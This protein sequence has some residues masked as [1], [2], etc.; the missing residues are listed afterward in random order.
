MRHSSALRRPRFRLSRLAVPVALVLLATAAWGVDTAAGGDVARNVE[1]AG[2]DLGGKERVELRAAVDDY[3]TSVRDRPVRLVTPTGELATTAGEL[4]LDVD[5]DGTVERVLDAGR[6]SALLRPLRWVTSFVSPHDVEPVFTSDVDA[7]Y[8]TIIGLEGTERVPPVEPSMAV[9]DG[10][11]VLVPSAPGSGIDTDDVSARLPAA[12]LDGADPIVLRVDPIPL[13]PALDDDAV[14]SVVEEANAVTDVPLV[15]RVADATVDVEPAEQRAWLRLA[16]GPALALDEDVAIETLAEE[17]PDLGSPP[18]DATVTLGDGG[19]PV[20]VPGQE[21]TGC[22]EPGSG[23]LLLEAMRDGD[24]R[25]TLEATIRPPDVTTD[26]VESWAIREPVGGARAWP[27]S[28]SGEVG[29]GF[30]TFHAAGEARV[31]NIQRIADLVRGAVIPPGGQFSVN[32][33]VGRRTPEKG[34]VA[35]GA[36][37]NGMHV[38][39]VGGGVSQFATTLFNAAY[40]AGLDIVEYQAHSEYFSRYPRG[41]EATMGYPAPDLRIENTTPFGVLIWTSY[42]GSSLTVTMYS[43]PFV[44][45]EQTDIREGSSGACDVVTTERTRTYPDGTTRVDEF[46]ATYRP[47]EGQFC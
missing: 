6:G 31:T 19:T 32:E 9:E 35:A 33:H 43:S 13:P 36:I 14:A 28:R 22:C 16:D 1:L 47:G 12:A 30:T 26:E 29:P 39:E 20:V 5:V 27:E 34:F 8:L 21:G 17:L 40:F 4:G 11:V 7:A 15:V 45:A 44:S 25:A 42:T 24:G 41:R 37:R 38:E 23:E 2:T 3:A 46:R 18:V 10:E